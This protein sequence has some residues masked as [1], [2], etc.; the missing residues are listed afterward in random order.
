MKHKYWNF[1]VGRNKCGR[2]GGIHCRKKGW[3]VCIQQDRRLNHHR[4]HHI[5]R[6]GICW[7]KKGWWVCIHHCHCHRV[8]SHR[9]H[10]WCG[11]CPHMLICHYCFVR[12]NCCWNRGWSCWGLG[13]CILA[14]IIKRCIELVSTYKVRYMRQNCTKFSTSCTKFSTSTVLVQFG[15]FP[16]R[17][18]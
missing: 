6:G 15:R 2:G 10:V 8:H 5:C 16:S 13:C 7:W 9:R 3:W 18:T 17:S 4:C 14:R 12:I 11:I 1:S